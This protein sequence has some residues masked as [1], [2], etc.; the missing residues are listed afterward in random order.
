MRMFRSFLLRLS[1]AL[2]VT[3]VLCCLL[4]TATLAIQ[5]VVESLTFSVVLLVGSCIWLGLN[6]FVLRLAD[7][8]LSREVAYY[9]LPSAAVL[10]VLFSTLFSTLMDD[11][12]PGN[13]GRE[14][15][16]L[17]LAGFGVAVFMVIRMF[18]VKWLRGE[19]EVARTTCTRRR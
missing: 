4:M 1:L 17:P 12:I 2:S 14:H 6:W 13:E 7:P 18:D 16:M 9:L 10:S 15:M 8:E 19:L 11:M 5:G 3:A